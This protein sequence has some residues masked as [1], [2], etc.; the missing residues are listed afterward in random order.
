MLYN[1]IIIDGKV[2]H[3]F[4][5]ILNEN[6]FLEKLWEWCYEDNLWDYLDETPEVL[7]NSEELEDY[8]L[9]TFIPE[10][11]FHCCEYDDLNCFAFTASDEKLDVKEY[12][13]DSA[14]SFVLDKIKKHYEN[15]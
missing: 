8:L 6:K 3:S 2:V 5:N 12:D 9:G 11:L 4:L 1:F 14:L 7:I 13:E 10:D 15:I